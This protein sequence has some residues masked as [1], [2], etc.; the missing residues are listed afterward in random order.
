VNDAI[1][2]VVVTADDEGWLL[3]LTR[4]LVHDR[5]VACG[6]HLT[7]V[8]S[9]YRWRGA[10]EESVETRVALHTRTSLVPAVID[11][12]RAEHPYDV[13]CVIALPVAQANPDYLAWVLEST[14]PR[15]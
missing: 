6:Q 13:P 15:N 9:V 12:V 3:D 14:D 7:P 11:R 4:A 2:E 1:C 10:I 5:L 8:R